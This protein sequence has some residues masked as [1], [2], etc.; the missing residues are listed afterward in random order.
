VERPEEVT[1]AAREALA[2]GKPTVLQVSITSE[3]PPLL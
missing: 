2:S 3:V 1:A